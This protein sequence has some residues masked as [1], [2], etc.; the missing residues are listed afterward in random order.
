MYNVG[1]SLMP[2]EGMEAGE[3]AQ[4]VDEVGLEVVAR[5]TGR[6]KALPTLMLRWR[7]VVFRRSWSISSCSLPYSCL[8]GLHG[9]QCPGRCARLTINHRLT[10]LLIS[11]SRRCVLL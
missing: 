8:T 5:A 6:Q 10:F 11:L 3:L 7:F 1:L 2:R 4:E 9:Q